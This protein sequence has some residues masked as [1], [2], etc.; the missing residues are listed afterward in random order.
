MRPVE[1]PLRSGKDPISLLR[2]ARHTSPLGRMNA[3]TRTRRIL[4]ASLAMI[5]LL[6]AWTGCVGP[7]GGGGGG[8]WFQDDTWVD[9]GG[10]AWY[11]GNGGAAYVHPNGGDRGGGGDR[12]GGG[13]KGAAA[14]K[15]GAG[16][17]GGDRR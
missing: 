1:D 8:V 5:G 9:G 14:E 7:G 16:D 11:G 13:D 4:L 12:R 2:A 17:K 3:K 15:G 10:R 6:I